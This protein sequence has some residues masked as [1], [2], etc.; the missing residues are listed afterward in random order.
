MTWFLMRLIPHRPEFATTMSDDERAVMEAHFA[1]WREHLTARTALIFSPV[2][3]PQGVWG[4]CV[5]HV[6]ERAAVTALERSDPAVLA[7]VGRYEVLELLDAV[8]RE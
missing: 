8:V 5:V 7:G 3:D 6:P 1:Y 2:A 4:M